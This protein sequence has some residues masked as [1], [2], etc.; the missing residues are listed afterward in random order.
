VLAALVQHA[1]W[2]LEKF[3]E[4]RPERHLFPFGKAQPTDPTKPATSFKAVWAALKKATSI[5]GITDRERGS[6]RRNDPR[7]RRARLKT[8]AEALFARKPSGARWTRVQ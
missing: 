2:Y 1:K 8:N 6:V 5:T 7:Y 4:I 3:G